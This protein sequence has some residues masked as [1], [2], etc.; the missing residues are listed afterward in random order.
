MK[1]KIKLIT[2]YKT[3]DGK[4]FE[5]ISA[6]E[7]HQFSLDVD[8]IQTSPLTNREQEVYNYLVNTD[9]TLSHIASSLDISERTVKAHSQKIYEKE[10]VKN[11]L[12]L[13]IKHFKAS[14]A[15]LTT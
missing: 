12:G 1:N 7:D 2:S 5:G 4:I 3:T 6:A 14:K 10:D 8:S 11:R 15:T 9:N 13:V